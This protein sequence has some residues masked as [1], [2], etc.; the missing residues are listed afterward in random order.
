MKD[1]AQLTAWMAPH[2]TMIV[3]V[4]VLAAVLAAV[5]LMYRRAR[6]G[7]P[8]RE[9]SRPRAEKARKFS[10]GTLSAAAAFVICTSI[11][12]NTSF[13][14]T[15]DPDGLKMTDT[16]ERV[17]ACAA[18]E[19]LM[20]M[21]VLGA[22]E[23]M[24]SSDS[25]S[26]GWYGGAVWV[27]AALSAIPAYVEG[28]GFTAATMV[29][30]IVG[31]FGSALAAHSALGLELRHR[32]GDESQTA[33]AQIIRDLRERLMARLGLA[34]RN[35]SAQQ[36]A[37]DRALDRAVDLWDRY[38]RMEEAARASKT[39]RRLAR[40]L[41]LWQDRAELATDPAQREAFRQR[42]AHRKFAT[43]L[44]IQDSESPWTQP[45]PAQRHTRALDTLETH[46][47]RIEALADTAEAAVMAQTGTPPVAQSGTHLPAQ[48]ADTGT[49]SREDDE[50]ADCTE[51]GPPSAAAAHSGTPGT[52]TARVPQQDPDTDEVA[53]EHQD[54]PHRDLRS[55]PTKRAALEALYRYR[56]DSA[57]TRTTNA[58]VMTLLDEL[59]Q[60]G[61]TLDRGTANRYIAPLRP[62]G[63]EDAED[64]EGQSQPLQLVEA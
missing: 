32:T 59:E 42:A 33:M 54:Q 45:S 29:R 43:A 2:G 63:S 53:D 64:R 3:A 22:R 46:A 24:S 14:F 49:A 55:Y 30:I 44:Q 15:G 18:F 1:F 48:R 57:D 39:G 56:I 5:T 13:R 17:L 8:S 20:A 41:A 61:I 6:V 60:H 47:E 21:C 58:I 10:I 25:R 50:P 35:R 11:S 26:P 9:L 31:S 16:A 23:R 62:T 37:R 40:R 38:D 4:C 19:S 51:A 27:F 34:H 12:L 28:N 36:I 7:V 52:V